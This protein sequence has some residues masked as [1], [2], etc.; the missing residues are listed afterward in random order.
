VPRTYIYSDVDDIIPSESV[1]GH[2]KKARE[3]IGENADVLVKLAKFEGST[4]VA[5]A[6]KDGKRYWSEVKRTW[7]T[8]YR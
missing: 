4:H 1:E 3:L 8:S 2:A 5:H 6:R 7:E